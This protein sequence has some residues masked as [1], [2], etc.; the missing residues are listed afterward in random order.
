[1]P[2]D[3]ELRQ[4]ANKMAKTKVIKVHQTPE[5]LSMND[6]QA[7][8][9]YAAIMNA[10][11]KGDLVLDNILQKWQSS[12]I[13]TTLNIVIFT[14]KTERVPI[15]EEEYEDEDS[16]YERAQREKGEVLAQRRK[17]SE[18]ILER[19]AE[20]QYDGEIDTDEAMLPDGI[21]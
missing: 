9:K 19:D 11:E 8:I 14:H 13:E 1:M 3:E 20:G 17:L 10:S 18:S 7:R 5:F 2:N 4:S 21:V 15:P 6:E 12:Q 16:P